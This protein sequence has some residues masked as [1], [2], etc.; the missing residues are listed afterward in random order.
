MTDE[1]ALGVVQS[2]LAKVLKLE[3]SD[4]SSMDTKFF[5]LGGTSILAASVA[6]DIGR[7]LGIKV[8]PSVISQMTGK[9][10]AAAVA[11]MKPRSQ[12][13][14][15]PKKKDGQDLEFQII[16]LVNNTSN[17]L[18]LTANVYDLD[19]NKIAFIEYEN[20]IPVGGS[21]TWDLNQYPYNAGAV[22][23]GYTIVPIVNSDDAI[24]VTSSVLQPAVL[25]TYAANG[26]TATVVATDGPPQ[27]MLQ[28]TSS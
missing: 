24:I 12:A 5:N 2:V 19:E 16:K 13:S 26:Q 21:G 27:P 8:D 28:L 20:A 1:K 7:A 18:I 22:A 25:L 4:A 3:G 9:E 17:P 6:S 11:K 15:A 14:T 10:L 23:A